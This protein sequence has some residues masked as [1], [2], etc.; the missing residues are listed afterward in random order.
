M[1]WWSDLIRDEDGGH[2]FHRFQ[3]CVWTIVLVFLFL[4]SV[5]SRLSMP[6]FS[7]TLLAVMGISGC[8]YPGFKIPENQA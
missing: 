7:A 5:W 2:S 3:I 4:N 8:T 6:E 1:R